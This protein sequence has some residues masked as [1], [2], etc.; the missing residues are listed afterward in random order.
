VPEAAGSEPVER[1]RVPEGAADARVM[2]GQRPDLEVVAPAVNS[3]ITPVTVTAGLNPI[4]EASK[5]AE[6]DLNT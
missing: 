3:D 4:I 1:R 6:L 2:S 5:L